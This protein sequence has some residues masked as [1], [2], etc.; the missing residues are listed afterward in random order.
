MSKVK[1]TPSLYKH[2]DNIHR[3]STSADIDHKTAT[4]LFQNAES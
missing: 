3:H 2:H 1:K 4:V